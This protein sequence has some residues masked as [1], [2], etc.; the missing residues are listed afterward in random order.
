M[1]MGIRRDQ[2]NAPLEHESFDLQDWY[3]NPKTPKLFE[4]VKGGSEAYKTWSSRIK[5][6]LMASNIARGDS[7]RLW[8][9]SARI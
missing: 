4:N 1:T 9:T 6:H 7:L 5:D 2:N 3:I 8:R